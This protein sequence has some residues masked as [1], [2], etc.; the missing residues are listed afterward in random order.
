MK[1]PP[2]VVHAPRWLLYTA[3]AAL[4]VVGRLLKRG[5]PL[6]RYRVRSIKELQFD[7]TS[8]EEKLAWRPTIG[9]QN[10]LIVTSRQSTDGAQ[11][12]ADGTVNATKS[13]LATD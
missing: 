4:E 10:G 12:C 6:S 9:V 13:V 3:G 8:A 1:N 7:C 5:V 11:S 2:R